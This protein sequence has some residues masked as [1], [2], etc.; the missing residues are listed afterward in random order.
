MIKI[1]RIYEPLGSDDGCRILV[2]RLW[3]RG[4]SKENAH[5]DLWM[6]DI[7][8]SADLRKWFSHDPA[9]WN[10]FVS[11]YQEELKDKSNLLEEI[12]RL[13]KA[14]GNVTLLFSARDTDHS[15]ATALLQTLNN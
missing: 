6:K 4:I 10:D 12:E 14:H 9:K 2:D 8:P 7:A 5:V 13:N 15:N 3:P 11:R 1:K